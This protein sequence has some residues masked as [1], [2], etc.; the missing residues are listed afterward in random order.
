MKEKA[1]P[2]KV[3]GTVLFTVVSVML[4]LIVFLMG[5]LALAATAS[6]RSYR[7]FQKEQTEATARAVLDS[8][9]EAINNDAGAAGG[10]KEQLGQISTNHGKT[11]SLVVEGDDGLK[12]DVVIS[13]GGPNT[14]YDTIN[15]NWRTGSIYEVNTQITMTSTGVSTDYTAYLTDVVA[16]TNTGSGSGGGGGG[17]FV[18]MGGGKFPDGGFVTGGT[19]LGLDEDGS[20]TFNMQN[21]NFT[22]DTNVFVNGRLTIQNKGAIRFNQL[23]SQFV[24]TGDLGY[25]NNLIWETNPDF[26]WANN[27]DTDYK[28][29]PC[30]Y[31]GGKFYD[32]QNV[33]LRTGN[34]AATAFPINL[35]CGYLDIDG[36]EFQMSGDIYAFDPGKTSV[37]TTNSR[38]QLFEWS[39]KQITGVADRDKDYSFGSFYSAG[40]VKL[41]CSNTGDNDQHKPK[42]IKIDGDLRVDKDLDITQNNVVVGG[43]VVV[44]GTLNVAAGATL[45]CENLYATTINCNGKIASENVHCGTYNGTKPTSSNVVNVKYWYEI[46]HEVVNGPAGGGQGDY[47]LKI[48][49]IEHYMTYKDGEEASAGW[50]N[51]NI[52][53]DYEVTFSWNGTQEDTVF[54]AFKDAIPI[55]ECKAYSG[56]I[57]NDKNKIWNAKSAGSAETRNG[58]SLPIEVDEDSSKTAR[59]FYGKDVYPKEF[60][61]DKY[62]N[63]AG[64]P[65][66]DPIIKKPDQS[67]YQ[68]TTDVTKLT[69]RVDNTIYD[70]ND[71]ATDAVDNWDEVID[72]PC[73]LTGT[74][75]G[76]NGSGKKVLHIKPGADGMVIQIGSGFKAQNGGKIIVDDSV[77]DLYIFIQKDVTMTL[78]VGGGIIT[79][80]YAENH[81][82]TDSEQTI[83]ELYDESKTRVENWQY[84]NVYIYSDEGAKLELGNGGLI[85]AHIRAP[86]LTFTAAAPTSADK[87]STDLNY[88]TS[89]GTRA[90]DKD[91]VI[92]LIGQ[93][94]AG[95]ITVENYWSMLYVRKADKCDCCSSCTNAPGCTC[96][97]ATCTYCTGGGG[98]G[99]G[100]GSYIPTNVNLMYYNYY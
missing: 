51:K 23:G 45:K 55:T 63:D 40:G 98:G 66:I 96:G 30:V 69:A 13:Y 42:E 33:T 15:D 75:D 28:D 54:N 81:V 56:D 1:I 83:N 18:S 61:Q 41:G 93:L 21:D 10:L 17:A 71:Y 78:P 50:I 29:I 7:T 44:N 35:Y 59:D 86:K 48:N 57:N 27:T 8:V 26:N 82:I 88:V 11:V 99:G 31:V 100:G 38:S 95:D 58:A 60:T 68:Y 47:T 22:V 20:T 91:Y 5:T 19:S 73:V 9:M 79:K 2:K 12:A 36:S 14:V 74:L 97:C 84:P 62:F 94:I 6:N 70:V 64:D 53:T 92:G 34:E 72:F 76:T 39:S 24:V 46:K 65:S 77:G 80:Q 52:M 4:V 3:K 32:S 16:I 89:D 43:D 25:G 67:K 85:T 90:V 37:I 49:L 87:R